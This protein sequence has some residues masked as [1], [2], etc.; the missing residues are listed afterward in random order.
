MHYTT[1]YGTYFDL[2]GSSHYRIAVDARRPGD[3]KPITVEFTY[4]H[5]IR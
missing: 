2:G 5:P 1:T 4:E 3:V